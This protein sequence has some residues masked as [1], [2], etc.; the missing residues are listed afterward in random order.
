M[1]NS[2]PQPVRGTLHF[3]QRG[4]PLL[5]CFLTTLAAPNAW[6]ESRLKVREASLALDEGV[7]ELD[8]RLD[9]SLP[10]DA[11]KAIDSGLTLRL[12]YEVE[13]SRVRRYL[14][15]DGVAALVQSYELVYHALSQR[16]LLRHLNS[17]VQQDFGTLDAALE[18]L[19][20]VS[21]LPVIDAALLEDG[22]TYEV[23]IR[24]V[25]DMGTAPDVF[26]WLLFWADDWSTASDWNTW[27]LRP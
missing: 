6:A 8:A 24:G 25:L 12:D 19:Q 1:S 14:P 22:S 20:V 3:L 16:Y 5:L 10:A 21:G 13:I 2:D 7:Y 15:D 11:R 4:A 18:R 23:R 9:L 17:G 27:T 26:G